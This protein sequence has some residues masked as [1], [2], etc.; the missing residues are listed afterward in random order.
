[1][2]SQTW[3]QP[4]A[5]SLHRLAAPASEQVEHLSELGVGDLVDELALEFD[6]LYRPLAPRLGEAYPGL[7]LAC[8]ELDRRL[9]SWR[10]GWTFADLESPGWAESRRAAAAALAALACE[11]VEEPCGGDPPTQH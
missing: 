3:L 7:S 4:L 5:T 9:V 1:M 10:L 6:D 8:R 11:T 2:K